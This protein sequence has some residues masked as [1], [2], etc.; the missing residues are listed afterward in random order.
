MSMEGSSEKTPFHDRDIR[1]FIQSC[2]SEETPTT[3]NSFTVSV[4]SVKRT[5]FVV[6]REDVS[7]FNKGTRR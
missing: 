6:V 4:Q 7:L 3:L 2:V 1:K 5:L